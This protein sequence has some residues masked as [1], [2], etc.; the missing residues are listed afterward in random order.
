MTMSSRLGGFFL[1]CQD[2]HWSIGGGAGE[3]A[4]E[5]SAAE[6]EVLRFGLGPFSFR[7]A[8][9][10]AYEEAAFLSNLILHTSI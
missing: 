4:G 1:P 9:A 6:G 5:S 3:A 10:W 7:W 2:L 8:W